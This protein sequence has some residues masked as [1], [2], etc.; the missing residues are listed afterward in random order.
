MQ[1]LARLHRYDTIKLIFFNDI[2]IGKQDINNA[3]YSYFTHQCQVS[4]FNIVCVLNTVR[5]DASRYTNGVGFVSG[6]SVLLVIY[7]VALEDVCTNQWISRTH[8]P[9]RYL[10]RCNLKSFLACMSSIR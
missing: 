5:I 9:A 7:V 3:H 8:W 2:I 10:I 6:R 1:A 4:N